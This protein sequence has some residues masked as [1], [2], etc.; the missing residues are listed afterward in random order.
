[1]SNQKRSIRTMETEDLKWEFDRSV[2]QGNTR[3]QMT[4][5]KELERR[6]EHSVV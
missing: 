2:E 1:M 4:V 5:I 6:G 3:R